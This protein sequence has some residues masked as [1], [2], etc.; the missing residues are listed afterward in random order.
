MID[1]AVLDDIARGRDL[2]PVRMAAAMRTIMTGGATPAQIGAFLMGLR[3]KGES[4]D[5][6]A[7]A[8]GV[9]RELA[10]DVPIEAELAETLVDTCG[11]GGD[12]S[13]LFNVSTAA[14]FVTAAAGGH[15]AKHGNRSVSSKSGSA[16]LLEAAGLNLETSADEVA[17]CIREFGVGFMFAPAHHGAMK[18]AVGVRRELGIRTLFNLLGPLTNPAGAKNQIMGVFNGHLCAP[19]A[20]VLGK[21]GSRHVMIVHGEDGLDELSINAP[22]KVAELRD[23]LVV[24]YKIAPEDVGLERGSLDTLRVGSAAESLALIEKAFAGQFDLAADIIAFNAGAAL[25]VGGQ[26]PNLAAGVTLAR[27]TIASGAAARRMAEVAA[28]TQAR[29]EGA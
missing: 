14:A 24:T 4:I 28:F 17:A 13:G 18:H 16:D 26:C 10:T 6:I 15:V 8:A 5:E 7:A 11:T 9:M 12:G 2:D 21:L 19:L 27:E 25:Y 22:T 3:M 20:E 1:A 29:P 23:G